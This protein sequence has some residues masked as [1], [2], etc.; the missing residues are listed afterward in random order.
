L[1]AGWA[2]VQPRRTSCTSTSTRIWTESLHTDDSPGTYI[3]IVPDF[4][5]EEI[6]PNAKYAICIT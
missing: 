4:D 3:R 1:K 2:V 6:A 5:M